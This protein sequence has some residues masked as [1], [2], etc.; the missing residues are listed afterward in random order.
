M[1]YPTTLYGQA[2]TITLAAHYSATLAQIDLLVVN[3]TTY[4]LLNH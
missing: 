3:S 1:L 2:V 4:L